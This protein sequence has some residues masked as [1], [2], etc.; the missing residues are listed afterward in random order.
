MWRINQRT[1]TQSRMLIIITIHQSFYLTHTKQWLRNVVF[2][3]MV[4]CGI[5]R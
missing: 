2:A 3:G 4:E 5:G 1:K